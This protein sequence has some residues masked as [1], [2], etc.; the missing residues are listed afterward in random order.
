MNFRWQNEQFW[1][2]N[3]RK[4][5]LW[6]MFGLLMKISM[7]FFR[8]RTGTFLRFPATEVPIKKKAAVGVRGI[9]LQKK[10]ELEKVYLFEEG[11]ETKILYNEKEVSLNRLKTAKRDGA[12]TKARK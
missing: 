3:F 11:T 7:S 10:D 1:L 12:G 6:S 2:Q 4:K 8:Q 9:R 5:I